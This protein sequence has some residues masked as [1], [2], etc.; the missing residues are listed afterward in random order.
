MFRTRTECQDLATDDDV[1]IESIVRKSII[2]ESTC[3]RDSGMNIV[4]V[5]IPAATVR[6]DAETSVLMDHVSLWCGP[7]ASIAAMPVRRGTAPFY[8]TASY[9][10]AMLKAYST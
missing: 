4:R 8:L 5:N 6:S 1:G 3:L 7:L 2:S 9:H 10:D